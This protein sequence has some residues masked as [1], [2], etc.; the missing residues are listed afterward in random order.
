MNY[1]LYKS[2]AWLG[3][4]VSS[5]WWLCWW[6]RSSSVVDVTLVVGGGGFRA[7]MLVVSVALVLE[8]IIVI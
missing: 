1:V 5:V 6:R 2:Y 7:G 4:V 3:L 8:G